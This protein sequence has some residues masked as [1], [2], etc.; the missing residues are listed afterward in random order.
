MSRA[1]FLLLFLG[2]LVFPIFANSWGLE[3]YVRL[4]NKVVIFALAATSLNLVL[5]Y[6]GMVSF[7]HAAFLG[8]GA[9]TAAILSREGVTS[10]W[11]VLG[12]AAFISAAAAGIIGGISLRTRGVYFIMITLAFAQ[13]IYYLVVSFKQYGGEDGLPV[14]RADFG[15]FEP[16]DTNLYFLSL[17]SLTAGLVLLH[18]ILH[19]RFGRVLRAVKENELRALTLGYPVYWVQLVA[20][21]LSGGLT[22]WAGALLAQHTQYVAPNLLSWQQSGHLMFMVIL[23]G[24]GQFWGGVVGATFLLV[25]EEILHD[26][27][28]HW[29]LGVGLLLLLVV[30]FAP[31]GL[32]GRR[33]RRPCSR[34][35]V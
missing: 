21:V 8:L 33:W 2:L 19:A 28:V 1:F 7:G 15:L 5:G 25:L 13:M 24:V 6:G 29:Q 23:G 34:S 9:Y 26:I 32:A 18:R 3:Y 12:A 4:L 16:T 22:G 35:R 11:L 20:F 31:D 14:R 17:G 10:G 27:T 30:L